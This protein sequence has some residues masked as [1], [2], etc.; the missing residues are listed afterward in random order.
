MKRLASLSIG[1][2][3][4]AAIGLSG[5]PA[6]AAAVDDTPSVKLKVRS[7][8]LD[9]YTG[10]I[11]VRVRVKCTRAVP[12]V[13]RA[14]WGASA[15]QD[16]RASAGEKVTCDGVR[17]RTS[18]ILDPRNGQ[19]HRGEVGITIGWTAFGSMSVVGESQ[20]FTTTV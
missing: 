18:L 4:A 12:G 5:S 13:G 10:N 20:G 7:I 9:P 6:H 15:R 14:A 1:V 16:R 19:F 2:L 8:T 3:I 17:R 11:E